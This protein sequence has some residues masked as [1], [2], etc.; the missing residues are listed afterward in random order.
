M[1]RALLRFFLVLQCAALAALAHPVA[2]GAMEISV[3]AD[4]ISI[5][6]RV[7]V[8]EAFVAA[9]FGGKASAGT[10]LDEVWQRHGEYLLAHLQLT[11][12]GLPLVGK[13]TA[14]TPPASTEPEARIAYDLRYE[15]P[16]G[17]TQP[18]A[19][20]LRQNVLNEFI[21]APGNPWEASY[22]VRL[23]LRDRP[24]QTDRLL[25]AREPLTFACNAAPRA[26]EHAFAGAFV[27]HGI[28]HILTGYDHLL[29]VAGLVLAVVS[30]LDL[31]KVV[32]AFTL[33]HTL[34]L[35]LAALDIVR[36]PGRI[37]EPMIAA[38]IVF[39]AL[40]NL[41]SPARSRGWTRLAVAF[42]FGLFHG[43]GFAGGLL[44]AM[45]GMDGI[46]I[47]TAIAAF[48]LGVEIG[49]QFVAL[50]LFGVMKILRSASLRAADPARIPRWATCIG[51]G[52][53]CAA[54]LVY[55]VAA[56]RQS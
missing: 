45:D 13:V 29:F 46:S 52:A 16:P 32:T 22:I 17:K 30:L 50:P 2:Q 54:G 23:S 34:T 42:G 11:A 36:L 15:L 19:I 4:G 8:E 10:T 41:V 48:S 5:H 40:Q 25:T 1:P 26:G 14:L 53:I 9:A 47:V 39:V 21:F 18:R 31:V 28:M 27:R 55:F 38:S 35:T 3:G 51:S 37:V 12:D 20:A 6:A 43:L 24:A 44:D 33:A 7:S 49:H 56:L